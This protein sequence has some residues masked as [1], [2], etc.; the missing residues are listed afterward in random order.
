[1]HTYVRKSSSYAPLQTNGQPSFLCKEQILN[2]LLPIPS[3]KPIFYAQL[4]VKG[5]HQHTHY[6][7]HLLHGK[8]LAY[9]VGRAE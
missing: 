6:E 2:I 3:S 7:P 5:L 9:A 8:V 4:H 1:M